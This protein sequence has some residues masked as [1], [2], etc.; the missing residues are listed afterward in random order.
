MVA[1]YTTVVS[2]LT[3]SF[4]LFR[5][6]PDVE[7]GPYYSWERVGDLDGRMIFVGR[8][9]SRSIESS[10]FSE[11][12]PGIY[13][14]DD[15]SLNMPA[16]IA[17]GYNGRKYPC[18]DNGCWLG[19]AMAMKRWSE[20]RLPS[21][22]MSPIWYSVSTCLPVGQRLKTFRWC[23]LFVRWSGLMRELFSIV[24]GIV[25]SDDHVPS[26]KWSGVCCLIK[27]FYIFYYFDWKV[28]L[29]CVPFLRPTEKVVAR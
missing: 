1:R 21:S 14:H 19:G 17:Y 24:S 3:S 18:F 23:L 27:V 2:D 15:D 16:M 29:K 28:Y 7:S 13:F 25:I 20:W 5:T 26:I 4:A 9:C 11:C 8:G 10:H 6:T 12:H 22:Y